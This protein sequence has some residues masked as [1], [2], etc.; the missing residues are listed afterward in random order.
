[1]GVLLTVFISTNIFFEVT[2]Q[3]F[4]DNCIDCTCVVMLNM[5][6]ALIGMTIYSYTRKLP[7]L[8][9]KFEFQIG[10]NS[11]ENRRNLKTDSTEDE[12]K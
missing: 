7:S 9:I 6:D 11:E 2:A 1:M 12:H 10:S 4:Q 8:S 5:Y 3:Q